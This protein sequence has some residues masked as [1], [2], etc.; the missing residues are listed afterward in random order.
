MTAATPSVDR[1]GVQLPA[2]NVNEKSTL[3]GCHLQERSCL[4]A[5]PHPGDQQREFLPKV[6][7]F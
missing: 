2:K 5:N 3:E 7:G 6:F 1:C 4:P